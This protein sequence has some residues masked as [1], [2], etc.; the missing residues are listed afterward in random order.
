MIR[1][2]QLQHLLST[3][4]PAD[5]QEE[6]HL[7]AMRSLSQQ[8]R[9]WHRTHYEPGHYTASAFVLDA[10]GH[11][12]LL[13]HHASLRRWLQPGG[14]LEATDAHPLAAARR[15]VA[16]ETGL[17]QLEAQLDG[18]LLDVDVHRIPARGEQPAHRHYDLRFLFRASA[19]AR[20]RAGSDARD[21]RWVGLADVHA[22]ESDASVQRAIGRILREGHGQLGG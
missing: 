17:H 1:V 11:R 6:A 3:H 18:A 20:P 2:Q 9:S 10:R 14:H 5:A 8:P 7:R 13:I 12:L 4:Q 21:A 15:E 19:G 16:E 22:L